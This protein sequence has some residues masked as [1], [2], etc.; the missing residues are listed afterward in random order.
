V[1]RLLKNVDRDSGVAVGRK[2]VG[3]L[4][5]GEEEVWDKCVG[6]LVDGETGEVG[7]G[8]IALTANLLEERA[9][10]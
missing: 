8:K 10:F 2:E 6:H 7:K 1:R 3:G 9:V 4:R 5:G